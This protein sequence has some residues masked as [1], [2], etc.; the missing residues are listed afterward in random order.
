MVSQIRQAN[1]SFQLVDD[2]K[3]R[4]QSPAIDAIIESDVASPDVTQRYA[5]IARDR[6]ETIVAQFEVEGLQTAVRGTTQRSS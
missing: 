6:L 3:C 1:S 5:D 2:E 4:R